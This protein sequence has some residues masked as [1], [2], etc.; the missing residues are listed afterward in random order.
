MYHTNRSSEINYWPSIS[1]MFLVFFVIALCAYSISSANANKGQPEQSIVLSNGD[2]LERK[3]LLRECEIFLAYYGLKYDASA[4]QEDE[5]NTDQRP[6]LA[7]LLYKGYQQEFQPRQTSEPT[8]FLEVINLLFSDFKEVHQIS[9]SHSAFERMHSINDFLR[10][11]L[12]KHAEQQEAKNN[13]LELEKFELIQKLVRIL[14]ENKMKQ[15]IHTGEIEELKKNKEE[16]E[17][18]VK[19]LKC[20]VNKLKEKNTALENSVSKLKSDSREQIVALDEKKVKFI[21]NESSFANE[22][23][24]KRHISNDVINHLRD[25][26]N[27]KERT[28]KAL[29]VEIIGH[30]DASKPGKSDQLIKDD[31]VAE[32]NH[33]PLLG[34]QRAIAIKDFIIKSLN[35]SAPSS[36]YTIE[37]GTIEGSS[38]PIYFKCYSASWLTPAKFSQQIESAKAE[39]KH[40]IYSE[41]DAGSSDRRVEVYIRPL[42]LINDEQPQ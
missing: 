25:M 31:C 9:E 20:E 32:D 42:F 22:D 35:P 8:D 26:A 6:A 2:M 1:D 23:V 28:Y 33:N 13:N 39:E 36:S 27:K 3:L 34:L 24:A 18:T 12:L 14:E 41:E 11:R 17:K 10:D 37:G 4:R 21:I 30:T 15:K 38:C 16:L 29:V 19:Q 40:R 5:K 7:A